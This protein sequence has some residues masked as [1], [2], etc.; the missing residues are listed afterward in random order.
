METHPTRHP[1]S[2]NPPRAGQRGFTLIELIIVIVILG[3][4]AATALPRFVDFSG[5]AHQAAVDGVRGGLASGM[6]IAHS[7]WL[8]RG[9]NAA[10]A[11]DMNG[12]GDTGDAEDVFFNASGWPVGNGAGDATL[13]AADCVALWQ[14]VLETNAPTVATTTGSD[15]QATQATTVCTYTYQ[16][17][18]TLAITYDSATGAVN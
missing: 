2:L 1:A 5:E 14:A 10:G 18:T 9:N 11:V 8:L 6:A 12:D 17:D 3:I 4:L 16:D 15:Y 7:A 13:A